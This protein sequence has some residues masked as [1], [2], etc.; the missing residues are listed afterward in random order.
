MALTPK[1]TAGRI[2][3]LGRYI[4]KCKIH[5]LF[6]FE[7]TMSTS[8]RLANPLNAIVSIPLCRYSTEIP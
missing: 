5:L 4:N 6:P 2:T 8:L 1:K 3:F 7:K